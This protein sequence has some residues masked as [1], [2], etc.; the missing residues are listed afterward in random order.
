MG[1]LPQGTDDLP[2]SISYDHFL[3]M[4]LG[5]LLEYAMNYTESVMEDNHYDP[6]REF[7]WDIVEANIIFLGSRGGYPFKNTTAIEAQE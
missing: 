4:E 7:T 6:P 3:L 1:T 2:A 5:W